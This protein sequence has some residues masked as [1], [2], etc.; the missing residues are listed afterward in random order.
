MSGAP[1]S[2]R[3]A[4][5]LLLGAGAAAFLGGGRTDGGPIGGAG[6]AGGTGGAGEPLLRRTVPSSGEALPAVGLGTYRTF[7]VGPGAARRPVEEVL[8]RFVAGGGTVVDSSPMYGRAEE[9]VGEL[10]A[11][12]GVTE[13][14]FLATK[15]WT[16]GRQAG[17]RQMETS[18]ERLRAR[19]IDLLQVH[20]L[21]D[22]ETQLETL[23]SWKA[24]GRI[25]YVGIT[26]YTT[27]A[28][29]ELERWI[30]EGRPDFV[31]LPY[32]VATP[33]A[34]RRLLPLAADRGVAV[35]VNEP[36]EGGAL[37]RRV[38]G[39]ELPPWAAEA[40]IG[41]WAQMFLKY[42]LAHPAVT[43]VIPATADP[44]H[45]EDDLAAGRGPLPDEALRRRIAALV[46]S[47]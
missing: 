7:D 20:N 25:R 37:F 41:S 8:R 32:S 18:L 46:A 42:I 22:V 5:R 38:R 17:L 2:R 43:C 9:V 16:R 30:V 13:E 19:S 40:G 33:E 35:L 27:S 1:L 28:F 4:V 24:A 10:A 15:V 11:K 44:E 23:R 21:L 3:S 36:F 39:R 34:A 31:Q 26:H 45:L 47:W 29:G 6:G 12:L 14:L